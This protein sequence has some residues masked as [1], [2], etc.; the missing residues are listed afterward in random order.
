MPGRCGGREPHPSPLR[1]SRA[2]AF[3]RT[4]CQMGGKFRRGPCP[5]AQMEAAVPGPH[6][7]LL[8]FSCSPSELC[9]GRADAS[10]V[11]ASVGYLSMHKHKGFPQKRWNE[12]PGNC[13]WQPWCGGTG[14]EPSP[15]AARWAQPSPLP[16]LLQQAHSLCCKCSANFSDTV[17]I[18]QLI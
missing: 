10:S 14:R 4:E 1:G 13:W 2:R 6:G 5:S 7:I 15:R 17:V 16:L 8:L 12:G 11:F 9:C 3:T 18:S